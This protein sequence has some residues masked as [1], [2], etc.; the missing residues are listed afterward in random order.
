MVIV[1][2]LLGF[3]YAANVYAVDSWQAWVFILLTT[4]VFAFAHF[5]I[6]ALYMVRSFARSP[7]PQSR[8]WWFS[9]LS[10]LGLGVSLIFIFTGQLTA[11]FFIVIVYFMFHGLLNEITLY[12]QGTAAAANRR[13]VTAVVLLFLGIILGAMRH[14]AAAFNQQFEYLFK[15]DFLL[16]IYW[17]QALAPQVAFWLGACCMV[18]AVWF[19]LWSGI[20]V[21][22]QVGRSV[23]LALGFGVVTGLVV[24]YPPNFV[25]VFS[26]ALLYHFAI[27]FLVYFR[28]IAAR[29]RRPL[30][31]YLGWHVLIIAPFLSLFYAGA[32][33]NWLDVVILNSYVTLT[34]T[35]IH[36][37]T[38]LMS[39]EW[40]AR[41]IM[42]E[43]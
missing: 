30:G 28:K 34:L 19:A 11:L 41:R 12:E 43:S 7:Q 14:S 22:G 38:S 8:Y 25:Y 9:V 10:A 42:N 5:L 21:R 6:G 4:Y 36:V 17:S 39:E 18:A 23:L 29:G 1:G 2:L 24:L 35:V 32:L 13:L 26:A 33:G 16:Q 37:T 20:K 27:W 31:E 3:F 15:N 40:F